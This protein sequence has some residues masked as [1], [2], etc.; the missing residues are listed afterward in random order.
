MWKLPQ[1]ETAREFRTAGKICDKPKKKK[2]KKKIEGSVAL[3]G[4]TSG[5]EWTAIKTFNETAGQTNLLFGLLFV[6]CFSSRLCVVAESSD[7][8][9]MAPPPLPVMVY[10]CLTVINGTPLESA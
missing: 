3:R 5:A 2:K 1:R 6:W 4:G 9:V 7:V 10:Q 8:F